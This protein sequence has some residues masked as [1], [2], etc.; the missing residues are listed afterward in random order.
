M[1]NVHHSRLDE[2]QI[3]SALD[4]SVATLVSVDDNGWFVDNDVS[5]SSS[6]SDDDQIYRPCK[7]ESKSEIKFYDSG[8]GQVAM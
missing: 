7:G 4:D 2:S 8:K 1:S 3:N 6:D 5:L